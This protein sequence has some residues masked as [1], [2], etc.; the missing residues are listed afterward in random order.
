V[1]ENADIS[2]APSQNVY[3]G[4]QVINSGANINA[5]TS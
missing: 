1:A 4:G 2:K 3:F 5:L